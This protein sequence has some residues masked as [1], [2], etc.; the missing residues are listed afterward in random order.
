MIVS[1]FLFTSHYRTLLVSISRIHIILYKIKLLTIFIIF[2]LSCMWEEHFKNSIINLLRKLIWLN[3]VKSWVT[4]S[5]DLK[6]L[7]IDSPLDTPFMQYFNEWMN[8][9][10]HQLVFYK[11][12]S[13]RPCRP[14]K[15]HITWN[16]RRSTFDGRKLSTRSRERWALIECELHS[17]YHHSPSP[18]W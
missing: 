5:Y 12:Y 15:Y 8:E 2:M 4:E 3:V 1:H 14:R 6:L 7:N 13:S 18:S 16:H 17:I 9:W 11:V 10:N